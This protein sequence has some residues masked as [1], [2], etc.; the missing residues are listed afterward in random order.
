MTILT[1]KA[2]KIDRLAEL[3]QS[4]ETVAGTSLWREAFRRMR[5][6]KMA[7]IGAVIIAVFVLVAVVGPMLAPHGATAQNWRSEVFPNQG[8][9]VGMRGENWF[10]LDHLGRDMFSRW[11]V[12]A[13]QTLLVGVVSMLIGLIV[14][15]LVGVLSGAAATLGGKAGQRVDTVI[16][17]C[18]DIMLS[19][20]SLLLAVSI[21]AVLGQ[22]LTTVM[23]A[24]GV[25]QI[26]IFARLLRGSMLVQ[27]GADYVLAAKAVGIRRKRI[28]LTQILP[29]S[30]SPVIVQATLSLATAII[31]AAALSYLGLGNP[32]PAVPEWGV[33]LSQAQRFFDNEPMMAAYPAVGIIITALGFTLL[34]EAMREALDPKLRG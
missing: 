9:F 11:L 1:N 21:A 33:M 17:R 13:R 30:L 31:E 24:V 4:S 8:K 14:G 5:S 10:G 34:G 27:G 7:V 15:A 19:L 32:D 20:P 18:T 28:V 29:N 6:S 16:M 3:T 22:S 26:P 2:D 12:G 23:I 25:V